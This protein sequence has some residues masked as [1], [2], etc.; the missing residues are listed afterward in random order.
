MP[1]LWNSQAISCPY[2]LKESWKNIEKSAERNTWA[3]APIYVEFGLT[4][5]NTS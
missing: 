1:K 2:N 4:T 5:L 3:T